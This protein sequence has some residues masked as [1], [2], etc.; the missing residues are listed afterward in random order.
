MLLSE[1]GT[2]EPWKYVVRALKR[3]FTRENMTFCNETIQ[4]YEE[5]RFTCTDKIIV[6]YQVTVKPV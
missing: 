6:S 1:T 5:K 3:L 2:I 4:R